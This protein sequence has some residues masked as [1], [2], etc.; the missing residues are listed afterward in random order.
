MK[1][2]ILMEGCW[3]DKIV[4]V[5]ASEELAKKEMAAQPNIMF[6]LYEWDV[7]E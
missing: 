4:G 7:T 3:E 5:Y 6:D 1:V 2:W